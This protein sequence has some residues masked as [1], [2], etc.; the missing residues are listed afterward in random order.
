MTRA[1]RHRG[2]PPLSLE[3]LCGASHA[4]P[5]HP[6]HWS[7]LGEDVLAVHPKQAAVRD[8]LASLGIRVDVQAHRDKDGVDFSDA[9]VRCRPDELEAVARVLR[10]VGFS[11]DV[12]DAPAGLAS[13]ERSR[14]ITIAEREG[15]SVEWH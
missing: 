8:A 3:L 10:N 6:G 1:S 5:D 12:L 2:S 11:G 15:W 4:P 14:I 13:E 7:G 9:Y